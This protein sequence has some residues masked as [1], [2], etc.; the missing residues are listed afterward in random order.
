MSA[1]A[2]DTVQSA[3]VVVFI[4]SVGK[5]D[6]LAYAATASLDL[7][8]VS[9]SAL[10]M[11]R[12]LNVFWRLNIFIFASL[13]IL[14]LGV[15][16][17]CLVVVLSSWTSEVDLGVVDLCYLLLLLHLILRHHV[18]SLEHI[19]EL[20]LLLTRGEARFQQARAHAGGHVGLAVERRL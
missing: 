10:L 20:S 5:I 7:L 15:V 11:T 12:I 8:F 19:L 4:A 1:L 13:L 2:L 6:A 18:V 9:E 3:I 14:L 16:G 17:H